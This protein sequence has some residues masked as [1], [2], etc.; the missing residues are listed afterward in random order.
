MASYDALLGVA[1]LGVPL[2]TVGYVHGRLKKKKK[3]VGDIV[4]TGVGA[5]VG[6]SFTKAVY[7]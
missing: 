6:T 3:R 4:G 2:A 7:S 5:I 1:K